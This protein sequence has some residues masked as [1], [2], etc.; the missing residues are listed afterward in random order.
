MEIADSHLT[1]L[2]LS[3]SSLAREFNVPVSTLHWAFATSGEPAACI[4]RRRLEQA[5]LEL[6]APLGRPSVSEVAARWQL[7]DSSHFIRAFK[8]QHA[9]TPIEFARAN[10]ANRGTG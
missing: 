10:G 5:R 9:Q 4:R 7:A 2:E 8:N 6:A 1:N 3:P